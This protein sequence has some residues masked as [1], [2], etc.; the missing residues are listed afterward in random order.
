MARYLVME[1]DG[2]IFDNKQDGQIFGYGT[3]RPEEQD[4]QVFGNGT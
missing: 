3:R 2:Q 4:G 1:K